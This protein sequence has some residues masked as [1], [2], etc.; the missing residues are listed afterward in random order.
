M[1]LKLKVNES[2]PLLFQLKIKS[3]IKNR[4]I[5]WSEIYANFKV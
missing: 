1:K 2:Y 5:L 3:L 4:N